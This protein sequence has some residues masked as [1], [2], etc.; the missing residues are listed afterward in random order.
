MSF[1][2]RLAQTQAKLQELKEK[3]NEFA[4]DPD[5]IDKKLGAID[6]KLATMI[7][8]GMDKTA[9]AVDGLD[10]K[11]DNDIKEGAANYDAAAAKVQAAVDNA[12]ETA[13]GDY[14]AAK[15][16][17]R[18]TKEQYEGYLNSDLIQTQMN[19][20]AV[21]TKIEKKKDAVDKAA[22]E[23]LINDLLDY[24][25]GCQ[26]MALAYTDEAMAAVKDASDRIDQYDAKYG[27]TE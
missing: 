17:V 20:E 10:G 26:A 4:S 2:E 22:M 19:L 11:I 24:A 12:L 3:F 25:D 13:D 1:E 15:E 5:A 14:Y 9:E 23:E 21:K 7:V 27:K 16:N 6:E 8:E 18:M